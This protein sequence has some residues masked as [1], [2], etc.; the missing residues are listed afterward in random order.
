MAVVPTKIMDLDAVE[1]GVLEKLIF[2]ETFDNIIQECRDLALPNVTA[3]VLKYLIQHKLVV[4]KVPA[5]LAPG[6]TKGKS[7]AGFMYDTDR[8]KDYT[9]Q[10]TA[11]GIRH[12]LIA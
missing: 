2:E 9:Y 4:A 8:M 11:K 12:L 7:K 6:E 10:A 3:D 5:D 1:K